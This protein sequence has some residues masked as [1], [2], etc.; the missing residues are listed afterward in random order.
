MGYPLLDE[1]GELMNDGSDKYYLYSDDLLILKQI[2]SFFYTNMVLYIITITRT[3]QNF[4]NNSIFK[5][6][7]DITKM[8]K[9]ENITDEDLIKLFKL[10][11]EDIEC[12]EKYKQNGEGRLT[13]SKIKEFKNW[14]MS[15]K[16][17]K[18]Q[19]KEPDAQQPKNP[20]PAV[21]P[22]D[23]PIKKGAK[24]KTFKKKKRTNKKFKRTRRKR[25]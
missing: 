18:L 7:P 25:R 17:N 9:K 24:I 13:E 19:T 14:R 22:P 11:K 16:P 21:S 5:L 2:Q 10:D 8:T 6:L 23:K 1:K 15:D 4:I 12:I 20:S 3:R